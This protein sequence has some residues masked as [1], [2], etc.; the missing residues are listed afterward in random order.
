M[1]VLRLKLQPDFFDLFFTAAVMLLLLTMT[2]AGCHHQPTFQPDHKIPMPKR[3]IHA[4]LNDHDEK[5]MAIPGVV[6]VYVG[7]L[8]DGQTPCLKVMAARKTPELVRQ[9]PKALEGYPVV[10]EETGI[11]RPMGTS[12]KP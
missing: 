6:G 8:E 12:P 3:D 4:V 11:I 10:V 9:I 2:W 1:R 5:L 7:L